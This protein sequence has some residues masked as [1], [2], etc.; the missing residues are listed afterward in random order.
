MKKYETREEEIFWKYLA[1]LPEHKQIFDE[2]VYQ[3]I[4]NAM[5]EF[6]EERVRES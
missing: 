2:D 4:L 1:D 5:R 3:S 6:A